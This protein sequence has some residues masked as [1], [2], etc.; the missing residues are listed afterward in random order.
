MF[1]GPNKTKKYAVSSVRDCK[2]M[3]LITVE[4]VN[5]QQPC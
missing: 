2:K 5:S 1:T 3:S 4:S